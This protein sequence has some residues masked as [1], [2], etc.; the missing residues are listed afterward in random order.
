MT[1]HLGGSETPSQV[2]QR[3]QRYLG[4]WESGAARMFTILD[5]DDKLGTIGHW[6]TQWHGQDV[7]ETGWFVLPQAQ[8]R[9]V[10]SRAVELIIDDARV[11]AEGCALLTAFPSVTNDASNALCRRSGFSHR[12]VESFPFRGTAL[13]VN[14]WV[15]EL[16]ES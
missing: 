12:G 4:F 15:L 9:G 7:L 10:A 14:A 8:G 13:T 11:H 2:E 6:A 3:H 5:G 16:T 1:Q